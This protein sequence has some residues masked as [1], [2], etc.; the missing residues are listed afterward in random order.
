[1]AHDRSFPLVT[2]ILIGIVWPT[3]QALTKRERR[4]EEKLPKRGGYVIASNPLSYID[5]FV[6]AQWEADNKIPPRYLVKDS[7]FDIP[8]GGWLMKKVRHIPVYRGTADAAK[9]LSAAVDAVKKGGVITI[10][11]EGTMTRDP[12]A[13]PMSGFN[14]AVRVAVAGGVPIVPVAQWGPQEILWPYRKG[15]NVFPRK[16]MH[17]SVGDP[18]DVSCLGDDPTEEQLTEATNLLM[19]KIT[20]L[21]AEI[22]G[23]VP[24]TPRI[25]VHTLKKPET[26]RE[27]Q[28]D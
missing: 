28:E 22:R 13:W 4:G 24:T 8:V 25:D 15:W 11:P 16:T 23:E 2:R 9:A 27:S 12:E 6:M 1:M 17:I 10:Y 20:E 14:G 18:I 26:N 7:V 19:D 21:Q 3:L 5:P